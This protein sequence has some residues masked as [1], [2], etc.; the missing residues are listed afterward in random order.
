MENN[1]YF[2]VGSEQFGPVSIE[3]LK[4]KNITPETLIW[5]DGFDDWKEAGTIDELSELF[6]EKSVKN[7]SVDIQKSSSQIKKYNG[8]IVLS[9]M[10]CA[11]ILALQL[12][13]FSNFFDFDTENSI[14]GDFEQ[15]DNTSESSPSVDFTPEM[16]IRNVGK[17]EAFNIYNN[18]SNSIVK[19]DL[20]E[21]L[22]LL[23]PNLEV[24]YAFKNVTNKQ[25]VDDWANN[26]SSKWVV[27]KDDLIDIENGDTEGE[28]YFNKK[29]II[30]SLDNLNEEREYEITGVF[31]IDK[32]RKIYKMI[33][34]ETKRIQKD[35][36]I[37]KS[38]SKIDNNIETIDPFEIKILDDLKNVN[39]RDYPIDGQIINKVS[40][41]M[42]FSVSKIFKPQ[43][44]IYVLKEQMNLT[45]AITN[46]T[47]TK[48]KDFKVNQILSK[49]KDNWFV[50]FLNEDNTYLNVNINRND[51][52]EVKNTWYYLM[53]VNGWI[54]SEFSK[55]NSQPITE[56]TNNSTG[57]IVEDFEEDIS[58]PFAVIEDVPVFP[59]CESEKNKRDCFNQMMQK[60]ISRNFSYPEIAQ[61]MGIQGRVYVT[62]TI[63]KDGSIGNI[64]LRGP[65]K[66]LEAEAL[67]IIEKLPKMVPGK[68][69]GKPVSVPYSIPITFRLQ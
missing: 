3:E 60:H 21:L 54:L 11:I 40:E 42:D 6:K 59:G 47:V 45:D 13:D 22:N 69:R 27:I 14:N 15:V 19:S 48:P 4:S 66:N 26:Y 43:N 62:F 33:D 30:K 28:F 67:R 50:E 61:E 16:S 10:V 17:A 63:Q 44:S 53:E 58:I 7:E 38:I 31:G 2:S 41:G 20:N 57:K 68:Q 46:E 36:D 51:L 39:V 56:N 37:E 55:L 25:A 23:A 64:R 35:L 18:F 29:Y 9:I 32:D 52:R 1:F 12:F 65:D 8:L 49:S 5:K 34:L 24:W